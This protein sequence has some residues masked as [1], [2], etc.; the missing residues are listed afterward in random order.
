MSGLA[1]LLCLASALAWGLFDTQR[2]LLARS[3]D[4]EALV[5]RLCLGMVPL[6]A[7]AI[8]P[9]LL[10]SNAACGPSNKPGLPPSLDR[11]LAKRPAGAGSCRRETSARDVVHL[12]GETPLRQLHPVVH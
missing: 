10:Q 2:K 9:H 12:E 7:G 4:S 3:L 8:E 1:L 11:A 6:A 5:I